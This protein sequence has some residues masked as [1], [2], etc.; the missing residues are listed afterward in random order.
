MF[1]LRSPLRPDGE[2]AT[3][4]E[5]PAGVKNRISHRALALAGAQSAWAK[6]LG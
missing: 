2:T 3:F 1:R 4:A 6:M 5:L